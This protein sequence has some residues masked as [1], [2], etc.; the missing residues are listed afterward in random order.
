M[1]AHQDFIRILGGTILAALTGVAACPADQEGFD[2]ASA[3]ANHWAYRP[4]SPPPI[5]E[6]TGLPATATHIDHFVLAALQ[7]A[8]LQLGPPADKR[9]LIRR[10]TFDLIG[11]PPTYAEVQEFLNDDSTGAFAQVID[12]LLESPR[13]GERWGRHWLDLARYADTHGGAPVAAKT[14]PFSYTYRDYVIGAFNR[15]LP[16]NRFIL[17]QIAADQLQLDEN[18]SALAALGFLTVGRQFRSY[19][20]TIDDRIDVVTRGLMGL[21]VTCARCHDHKYDA[22]PTED[23]Y[24]LYAVFAPSESPDELPLLGAPENTPEYRKFQKELERLTKIR[25]NSARDLIQVLQERLRMQVGLYLRE[26]AKGTPE[27]DLTTKFLSYRTEDARP[28]IVDRWREYLSKRTTL[29]DPVFGIWHRCQKLEPAQFPQRCSEIVAQMR[30]DN[31]EDGANPEKYHAPQANPPRWNP[32]VLEVM[33]ARS[34]ANLFDL[35]DAYGEIFCT[36]QKEWLQGMLDAALQA[37]PGAEVIGDNDPEHEFLNSP[38]NRQ[39]RQHLHAP[40]TPTDI[41]QPLAQ[42]LMNRTY[43]DRVRGFRGNI[44]QLKLQSPDSPPRSMILKESPQPQPQRVFLRGNPV[45]RGQLVAPRFPGLLSG[46]HRKVFQDGHRRLDLARAIIDP[47]NPLTTRFIV[48]WVWQHHFGRGLVRTPD[49]FGVRGDPPTHPQLLDYLATTYVANGWSIKRLHRQ[50]M[51][52]SVYQQSSE[53]LAKSAGVPATDAANH[54]DSATPPGQREAVDPEN[55]LLWRMPPKR[56]E[57]EAMRDA[58]LAVAGVLDTTMGGRPIDLFAE[59]AIAR[60]TVYGFINRDVIASLFGTF[61]MADPSSCTARRPETNVPQ[62][63]LFA[64]NSKFVVEQAGQLAQSTQGDGSLEAPDRIRKLYQRAYARDPDDQELTLAL[65]YIQAQ[66]E[67]SQPSPWTRFAQVL[68]AAN[69][70]LFV[71]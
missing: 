14:F 36:I 30:E 22:I 16:Y 37:V 10:A 41:S 13:Y 27:Q 54:P 8:G 29:E 23:Y 1:H 56:L 61:D 70:F 63:A 60:R 26:L 67:D 43:Q 47:A 32:R 2:F 25:N 42:Q 51:L 6:V 68:L 49:N 31:G 40:G 48:N 46:D 59:P 62:Q 12:R 45:D 33:E 9:T 66:P 64:L 4:V 53:K 7:K 28:P 57:L 50:I 44:Q 71:D 39:L 3:R 17:E 11:L 69:E 58:M 35:A 19:H 38:V 34:P 24:S 15:D 20:D 21:N 52:S 65:Q 5:P 55:R 18:D